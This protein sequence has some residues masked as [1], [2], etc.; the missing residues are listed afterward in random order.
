[1]KPKLRT[2]LPLI[3]ILGITSIILLQFVPNLFYSPIQTTTTPTT[4]EVSV[5]SQGIRLDV[6]VNDT[7]PRIGGAILVVVRITNVNSSDPVGYFYDSVYMDVLNSEGISVWTCQIWY[8]SGYAI[9][10]TTITPGYVELPLHRTMSQRFLWKVEPYPNS[11]I[12]IKPGESY[13]IVA[14]WGLLIK[15]EHWIQIQSDPIRVEIRR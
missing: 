9:A 2:I 4:T 6:I 10:I 7:T 15:S 3:G 12:K 13:Y 8:S 5:F 11:N 1:M 14:S